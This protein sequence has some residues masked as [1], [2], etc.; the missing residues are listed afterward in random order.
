MCR[1]NFYRSPCHIAIYHE[2]M[3]SLILADMEGCRNKVFSSQAMSHCYKLRYRAFG[4]SFFLQFLLQ[5]IQIFVFTISQ[6]QKV[7]FITKREQFFFSHIAVNLL[8]CLPW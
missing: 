1:S 6:Y 2:T 3:S 7:D 8:T 4:A 5:F